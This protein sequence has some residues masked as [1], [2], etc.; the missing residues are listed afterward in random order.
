MN[1]EFSQQ[2]FKKKDLKYQVLSKSVQWEQSYFMRTDGQMDMTKII[3][4]FRNFA[5]VLKNQ[6]HVS[7]KYLTISTSSVQ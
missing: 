7:M 4:A 6:L 5:K 1:L 3:V 2:I